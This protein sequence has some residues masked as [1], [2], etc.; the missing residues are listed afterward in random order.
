LISFDSVKAES[1]CRLADFQVGFGKLRPSGL[2]TRGTA[3]L[4]FCA[5]LNRHGAAA[6]LFLTFM[7]RYY[8][9]PIKTKTY[10]RFSG[11]IFLEASIPRKILTDKDLRTQKPSKT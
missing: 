5:T 7:Q 1:T 2:E 8:Q 3:D 10:G 6:T 4:E 9:K 11:T